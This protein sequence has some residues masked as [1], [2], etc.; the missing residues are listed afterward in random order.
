[1]PLKKCRRFGV[2]LCVIGVILWIATGMNLTAS[3]KKVD[4]SLTLICRK[5]DVILEGMKW[6]LYRVGSR[7]GGDFV[8]EGDFADYPVSLK[9]FSAEGM[10]LA[11]STLENFAVLDNLKFR[12]SG[13][14]DKN[15]LLKFPNLE[16]G[17]YMVCGKTLN[18]GDTFYVPSAILL[19]IRKDDEGQFELDL[20]AYPKLTYR[21]LSSSGSRYT[22]K[23]IWENDENQAEN[24]EE[25]ITVQVYRDEELYDTVVL[26]DSNEWTHTWSG[27]NSVEWRVK[28]VEVPE[29]YNV[30]Y[31]ANETQFA[32]VNTYEPPV[33]ETTSTSL[34][35][36]TQ[37]QT[38]TISTVA[39]SLQT[40]SA[41]TTTVSSE[42]SITT[43]TTPEKLPQTG[44][45]W[46]PVPVMACAGLIFIGVGIRLNVKK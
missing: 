41:V 45:L 9:N 25:S 12:A 44:Q 24:R 31:R 21:V 29:N 5:D 15:G 33:T 42:S 39:T 4:G 28:E 43:V 18:I 8:L 32:I 3:A 36:T 14:T 11:A 22:V 46:W 34:T 35:T 26:D 27:D 10:S 40:S 6:R 17:L 7:Q 23:K 38:T 1:M 37:T 19:E 20:M 13:K 16:A 30:I 2:F